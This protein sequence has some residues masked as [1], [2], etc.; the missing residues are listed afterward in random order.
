MAGCYPRSTRACII[1]SLGN[2]G[3]VQLVI[4]NFVSLFYTQDGGGRA[5]SMSEKFW[6]TILCLQSSES[7]VITDQVE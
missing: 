5:D 6:N 2:G 1:L 7:R 3:V 4:T